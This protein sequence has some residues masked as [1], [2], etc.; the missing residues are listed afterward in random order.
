MQAREDPVSE[1]EEETEEEQSSWNRRGRNL[2]DG[3]C[4]GNGR[5]DGSIEQGQDELRK[6]RVSVIT[7]R[8]SIRA[9]GDFV[10]GGSSSLEF[11]QTKRLLRIEL[12]WWEGPEQEGEPFLG[13]FLFLERFKAATLLGGEDR[14]AAYFENGY[15]ATLTTVTYQRGVLAAERALHR[16][17]PCE[18]RTS[19]AMQDGVRK[20]LGSYLQDLDALPGPQE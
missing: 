3:G 10:A 8:Q 1:D 19:T 11:S 7:P 13:W 6:G 2:I 20:Y 14:V 4:S 17:R 16:G 15:C 12:R 9:E 18:A 5:K